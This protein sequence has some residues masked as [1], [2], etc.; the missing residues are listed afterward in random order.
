MASKKS[1]LLLLSHQPNPRFVKQVNYF[2]DFFEVSVLFYY[3]DTLP[4]LQ[5]NIDPRV[6]YLQIGNIT[7]SRYML[8]IKEYIGSW[9]RLRR[10]VSSHKTDYVLVN[11]FDVLMFYLIANPIG[12]KTAVKMLE[13]SDLRGH[14]YKSTLL[15]KV[16][17]T[18]ES[19][20]VKGFVDKLI[21]TS[22]KFYELYYKK[23]FPG[24][25]FLLEN[26]PLSGTLPP[27]RPKKINERPVIG[28]VGLLLQGTPYEALFE[29]VGG[30]SDVEVHIYGKGKFEPLVK[31]YAERFENITYFGPYDF[32][33]E[34]SDIYA[35]I[36][37]LYMS[38][39]TTNDSLNNRIA[40]P[41]KLYEAMYYRVPVLTSKNTLLGEYIDKYGMGVTFDCCNK[42]QI[43]EAIQH[44]TSRKQDYLD[45]LESIDER[46]YIADSD[47]KKLLAY[48]CPEC[49]L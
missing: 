11:N 42:E 22:P 4:D 31:S 41:N 25:H 5:S 48:V 27:K 38:Y 35:S 14:T 32:F 34:A 36:D 21:V 23:I 7:D 20:L 15:S 3:R 29:T 2:A 13:I 19:I 16:L 18:I 37:M 46:A 28:I 45:H 12:Q 10:F 40:L 44:T 39:D 24:P 1:L 8:R 9:K 30:R 33:Q 47:Y 26:K 43:L 17:R 49:G 6:K